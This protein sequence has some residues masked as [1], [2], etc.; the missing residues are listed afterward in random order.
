MTADFAF[1][2]LDRAIESGRDCVRAVEVARGCMTLLEAIYD[3]R[4]VHTGDRWDKRRSLEWF[5][6]ARL[7]RDPPER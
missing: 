3:R 2:R 6:A 5:R 7:Q 4:S 1:D